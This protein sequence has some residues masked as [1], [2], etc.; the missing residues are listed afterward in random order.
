MGF[1][2]KTAEQ[3]TIKTRFKSQ[4]FY[5]NPR[6]NIRGITVR[7]KKRERKSTQNEPKYL[8]NTLFNRGLFF[9]SDRDTLADHSSLTAQLLT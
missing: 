4:I 9:S 6:H 2:T 8:Q 5:L 3:Q 1:F 7:F